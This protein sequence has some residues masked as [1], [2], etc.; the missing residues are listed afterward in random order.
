M[1]PLSSS[2][3]DAIHSEVQLIT[4]LPNG[5]NGKQFGSSYEIIK[6]KKGE[7]QSVYNDSLTRLI[8]TQTAFESSKN[9]E[10]IIVDSLTNSTAKLLEL[11]TYVSNLLSN[12]KTTDEYT[13]LEKMLKKL[14]F[15]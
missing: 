7:C 15:Y 3:L 6:T 14:I 4:D 5:D 8:K 2:A 1:L 9:A 13:A 12:V 10:K 11:Q